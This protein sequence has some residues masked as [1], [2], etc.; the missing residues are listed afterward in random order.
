VD[1][2]PRDDA[3]GETGRGDAH[4]H[5]VFR[6]L[7]MIDECNYCF[8]RRGASGSVVVGSER[9]TSL[10]PILTTHHHSSPLAVK[11]HPAYRKKQVSPFADTTENT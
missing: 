9:F 7:G 5:D 4:A 8:V 6:V 11:F 2:G 3:G 10:F 1:G